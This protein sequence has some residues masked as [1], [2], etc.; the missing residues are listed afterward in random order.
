VYL[1]QK[2]VVKQKEKRITVTFEPDAD[3]LALLRDAEKRGRGVRTELI[4]KAV[5]A[6]G[7]EV[8]RNRD[9]YDAKDKGAGIG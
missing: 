3:V 7:R 5:R 4:N 8:L 2:I 9:D 1:A 6:K